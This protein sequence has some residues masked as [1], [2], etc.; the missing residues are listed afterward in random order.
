MTDFET[1]DIVQLLSGGPR[2][3]VQEWDRVREHVHCQWFAGSKLSWG[4]FPPESLKQVVS[5]SQGNG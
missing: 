4:T 3:T 5:E 2:M 1:G